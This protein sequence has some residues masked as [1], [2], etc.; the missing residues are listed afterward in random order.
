MTLH[1]VCIL[2][3]STEYK[4]IECS[5]SLKVDFPTGNVCNQ[6]SALK[7]FYACKMRRVARRDSGRYI[8]KFATVDQSNILTSF[9]I[10]EHFHHISID[11]SAS[12]SSSLMSSSTSMTNS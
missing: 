8:K 12:N 4:K 11:F 3:S 9:P 10:L 1:L 7:L 5:Y 6:T 2:N